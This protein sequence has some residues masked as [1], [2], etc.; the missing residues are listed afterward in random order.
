MYAVLTGVSTY[1]IG[2][3][4]VLAWEQPSSVE[5]VMAA[6]SGASLG[7]ILIGAILMFRARRGVEP[8][9]SDRC[10]RPENGA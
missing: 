8:V 10:G 7:S 6:L 1:A 9:A 4:L 5:V 3:H 2:T